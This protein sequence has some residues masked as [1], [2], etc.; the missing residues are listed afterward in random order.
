MRRY[1]AGVGEVGCFSLCL[2][3]AVACGTVGTG[4]PTPIGTFGHCTTT[5][6]TTASE[7]ILGDVTTALATGDYEAAIAALATKFGADE[8]GCAVDLVIAEFT[9]KASRTNDTQTAVILAHAQ[10]IRAANP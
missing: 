10:A 7:G 1:E 6:L 8:V 3:L 5:A 4:V 9:A 2:A